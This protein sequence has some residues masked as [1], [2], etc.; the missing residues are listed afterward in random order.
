MA[1]FSCPKYFHDDRVEHWVQSYRVLLNSWNLFAV[2]A[3]FDV[4][5]TKLSR[6]IDGFIQTKRVPRQ[7]Y[8]QCVN[9]HKNISKTSNENN[10][11]Q[12]RF[13]SDDDSKTSSNGGVGVLGSGLS[14]V[15]GGTSVNSNRGGVR[16][17]TVCPHCG[18]SLP[19]CAICLISQG[20][21]IPKDM[22]SADNYQDGLTN[23]TT[24][25]IAK[26]ESKF[27]EWFSFC[28]SCN[29]TMHAGHAE[30]WFSKHWVCPVPDCNC[31]CNNK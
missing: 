10:D 23:N 26:A 2:R 17:S 8:L 11:L 1:S 29:H 4:A 21:P 18:Y 22:I 24:E 25:A 6:R 5:R 20:I 7:I 28:L 14:S 30:E 27:K 16:H 13:R 19:R 3:R 15:N 31:K 12:A 9:C